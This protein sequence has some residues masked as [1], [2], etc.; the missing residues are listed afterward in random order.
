MTNATINPYIFWT[1]PAGPTP[2]IYCGLIIASDDAYQ[3][4]VYDCAVWPDYQGQ[5][6][7]AMIMKAILER[8]S[9]CNVILYAAVGKQGFYERLGLNRMKTGMARFMDQVKARANGFV[10]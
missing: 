6:I 9:H 5:G 3:A 7:G 8:V 1:A 4:A 2:K 10:E